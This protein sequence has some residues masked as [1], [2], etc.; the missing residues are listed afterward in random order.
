M[1][2]I[3]SID[4]SV[5]TWKAQRPLLPLT[6]ERLQRAVIQEQNELLAAINTGDP[7]Q[8]RIEV[9]DVIFSRR[10]AGLDIDDVLEFCQKNGLDPKQV[11]DE[12]EYRVQVN[13]GRTFFKEYTPFANGDDAIACLRLFRKIYDTPEKLDNLW[14]QIDRAVLDAA[15]CFKDTWVE[16]GAF[17]EQVK[18]VLENIAKQNDQSL[19]TEAERLISIGFWDMVPFKIEK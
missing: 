3:E 13:Y 15:P 12:T 17:R 14:L 11:F 6:K 10:A 18:D 16:T 8:L 9:G 19:A 2:F 5:R 7:K 1:S 4:K